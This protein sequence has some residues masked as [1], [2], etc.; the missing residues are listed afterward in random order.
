[1]FRNEQGAVLP[2]TM[3]VAAVLIMLTFYSIEK[4][5][6]E[7]MFYKNVED[8]LVL[9]HILLLAS[10]KVQNMVVHDDQIDEG[11]LHFP[12][13]TVEYVVISREERYIS[14]ILSALTKQGLS[15]KVNFL[16]DK[17][18]GKLVKW[19]EIFT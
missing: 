10:H 12:N 7:K 16:Y 1:M 5:N 15:R 13:G 19:G 8:G 11:V 14:L 4:F 6:L 17:E 2:V 18:E 3:V 9:D